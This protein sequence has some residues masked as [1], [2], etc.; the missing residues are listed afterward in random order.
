MKISLP[1]EEKPQGLRFASKLMVLMLIFTLVPSLIFFGVYLNQTQAKVKTEAGQTLART[2]SNLSY[3]LG[4]RITQSTQ[5]YYIFGAVLL[6]V[7]LGSWLC[8]FL[9]TRS[10]TKL[11]RLANRMSLGDLNVEIPEHAQGEIGQ[12]SRSL[13]RLQ[14]SLK[15]SIRALEH[16]EPPL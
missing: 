1:K 10:L 2:A 8:S 11:T 12:L 9:F 6:Y 15:L 13:Q 7:I 14:A 16:L 4:E 3:P 5:T